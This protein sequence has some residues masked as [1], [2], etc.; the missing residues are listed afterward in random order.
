MFYSQNWIN[1][2]NISKTIFGL[3]YFVA[4][5]LCWFLSKKFINFV[6]LPWKLDYPYCHKVDQAW[7]GCKD[8]GIQS[9][10]LTILH[11]YMQ[12]PM[13]IFDFSK[14][15]YEQIH[16]LYS[17]TKLYPNAITYIWVHHSSFSFGFLFSKNNISPAK[18]CFFF[19][20]VELSKH[21]LLPILSCH[22]RK[23]ATQNP[24]PPAT[25]RNLLFW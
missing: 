12:E 9:N 2:E 10:P 25:A 19:Y 18:H 21:D 11:T 24:S 5:L 22:T 15:F 13:K 6:S 20:L 3:S 7:C 16:T 17:S 4:T 1:S 8:V 23:S 14:N